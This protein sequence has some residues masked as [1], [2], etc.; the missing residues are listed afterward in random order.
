MK[1][2]TLSSNV[3]MGK[4][5]KR[6]MSSKKQ[7]FLVG[8]M[9]GQLEKIEDDQKNMVYEMISKRNAELPEDDQEKLLPFVTDLESALRSLLEEDVGT[10]KQEAKPV[11]GPPARILRKIEKSADEVAAARASAAPADRPVQAK[12]DD[13]SFQERAQAKRDEFRI[14]TTYAEVQAKAEGKSADEV[15]EARENALMAKGSDGAHGREN[16]DKTEDREDDEEEEEEPNWDEE[17]SEEDWDEDESD[18]DFDFNNEEFDEGGFDA[19]AMSANLLQALGLDSSGA[20]KLE[21]EWV[22]PTQ[23]GLQNSN[24][25]V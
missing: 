21:T 7:K 5:R 20:A 25:L 22:A 4:Q 6:P 11:A 2:E 1:G 12:D 10:K 16:D 19:S 8:K 24:A 17:D 13:L 9:L 18:E 3:Y 15:R 14:Q 23:S